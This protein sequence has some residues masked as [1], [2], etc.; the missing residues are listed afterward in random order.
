MKKYDQWAAIVGT[1]DRSLRPEIFPDVTILIASFSAHLEI[2]FSLLVVALPMPHETE[3]ADRDGA[4]KM[5]VFALE[6][7]QKNISCVPESFHRTRRRSLRRTCHQ[8]HTKTTIKWE[9]QRDDPCLPRLCFRQFPFPSR[10]YRSGLFFLFPLS[11]FHFS[12]LLANIA[13]FSVIMKRRPGFVCTP[14]RASQ[15]FSFLINA[16][17]YTELTL[18]LKLFVA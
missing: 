6:Y 7:I 3:N 18:Q 8:C 11:F 1:D 2:V 10:C 16:H 14:I 5:S 4:R 9:R 15:Y 13:A 12:K 17:V